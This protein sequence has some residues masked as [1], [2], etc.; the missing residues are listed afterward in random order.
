METEENFSEEFRPDDFMGMPPLPVKD[1]G[2]PFLT[3]PENRDL[4][5]QHTL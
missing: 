4:I 3:D 2:F 5:I 1:A